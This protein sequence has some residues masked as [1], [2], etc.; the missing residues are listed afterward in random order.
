MIGNASKKQRDCVA[1]VLVLHGVQTTNAVTF[2]QA[3][4][5]AAIALRNTSAYLYHSAAQGLQTER[6]HAMTNLALDREAYLTELCSMILDSELLPHVGEDKR[7]PIRVSVG[8][9]KGT[10]GGNKSIAQCWARRMSNDGVNEIFVSPNISDVATIAHTLQHEL[11]HAILDLADGHKGR[12][13]VLARASGLE[14]KLTATV[15]SVAQATRLCEL[16]DLLGD[17]PHATLN[18]KLRKKQT[19]RNL[20]FACVDCGFTART[21]GKW[22]HRIQGANCPACDGGFLRSDDV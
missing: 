8:W 20:K 10:R 18:D 22:I 4:I 16:T 15:A 21:S 7:P 1:G 11:I 12:F 2:K 9:P 5:G 13:A 19:T 6:P 3:Y 14:G 17:Y